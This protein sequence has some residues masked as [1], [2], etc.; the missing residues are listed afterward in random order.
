MKYYFAPMEGI[1]GY[2][3]RNV[4]HDLF[5]GA[6]KYFTPF[7]SP[8]QNRC[9]TPREKRDILPENNV[10]VLLVPQILTNR[11]D[12]F[13]KTVK[14][15]QAF[16]YGEVNL[17]LGCPSGTVVSKGKGAGFL[18]DP[19]KLD[20]FLEKVFEGLETD[21]EMQGKIR[22][23]VKTRIG[24]EDPE[25][26]GDLMRVFNRY[27]LE[28]LMI[29]PRVRS[30]F[31]KNQPD[32]EVFGDALRESRNPVC[33]NGD[34]FSVEDHKKLMEHFP[35]LQMVMC[36]R[37]IL[38]NPALLRMLAGGEV[39][40]REEL[41][42]FHDNIYQGYKEAFAPD[43]RSVLFKMKELWGYLGELFPEGE[44]TRK[45]IRKAQHFTDYEAAIAVIFQQELQ[46]P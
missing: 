15:L 36:G 31:Y 8:N 41:R 45:K 10:G 12:C 42:E 4:H 24:M 40:N 3:Y 30:D 39:L 29:H 5:P 38:G 35:E 25:E 43:E 46:L 7:L 2:I 9:F 1:T 26:F 44:K 34:I 28:E 37:G 27:P 14:E 20:A 17:N 16:G 18:E 22:V 21:W 19:D 11:A 32:W 6:D 23:S 33:Y 13:L